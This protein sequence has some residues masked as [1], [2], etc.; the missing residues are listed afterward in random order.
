MKEELRQSLRELTGLI[1]VS[2]SEQMVIKYIKEKFQP[3][4][5]EVKVD[6]HGNV[7][8]VKHGKLPGPKI[9]IAAHCDEIGY[10]VKTILRNGFIC[11]DKVGSQTDKVMEGRKVWVK[12]N[13]PGVIGIKPGHLSSPDESRSIK[14]TKGCYIDIGASS[15]EE[16]EQLGIKIGDP[17]VLQSD[18]MEMANKDL[19]CTKAIDNRINCAILLK[20]FEQLKDV[21]FAGTLYGAVTVQEETG[22]RGALWA[23]NLIRPDY[24]VVIDTIPAGD[25]PDVNSERELP[26]YLG[27]GPACPVA[28]G[29]LIGLL[30]TFAHPKVRAMVEHASEKLNIP[31]QY[32][33]LAGDGY[34]TDSARLNMAG[35]GIPFVT[36]AVP[37]RYSHS[38][39]ELANLNDA[40]GSLEILKNI[41]IENGNVNLSFI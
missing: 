29:V 16:V 14:T 8:A 18:F 1:G 3:L 30:Y 37:R 31:V 6:N 33:T 34:A 13:I 32:L 12:N 40:V 26:I 27:K 17:I 20:L 4:A 15:K 41:V 24:A 7:I 21:E 39:I 25:T 10:C 36:L 9:M 19:V 28:D 22:M 23:G 11:F 5:D 2:G 35:T 38:P